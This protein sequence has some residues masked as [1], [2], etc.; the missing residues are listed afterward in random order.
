MPERDRIRVLSSL[1]CVD[2]IVPFEED[3]LL[4]MIDKLKPQVL[5]KGGDYALEDVVG[6]E[7]VESYGGK[8]RLVPFLKGYSTTA[9]E[10]EIQ[11]KSITE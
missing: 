2:L 5:V 7:L 10:R 9:I 11:R 1:G 3:T 6:R 4:N 8:V